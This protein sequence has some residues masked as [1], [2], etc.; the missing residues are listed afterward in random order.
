M[1]LTLKATF[2]KFEPLILNFLLFHQFL[3]YFELTDRLSRSLNSWAP[4]TH[5]CYT[6]MGWSTPSNC[7]S[8]SRR[9]SPSLFLR[10][11]IAKRSRPVY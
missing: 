2:I 1:Q 6:T 5:N 9:D 8:T 4:L 10:N 3:Y 7:G 11:M